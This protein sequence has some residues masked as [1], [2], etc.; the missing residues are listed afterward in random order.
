MDLDLNKIYMKTTFFLVSLAII[1]SIAVK[2][3]QPVIISEDSLKIGKSLMP[4]FSVT[5]PE[6]NYDKTMKAWIKELQ[7]GTKSDV[8]TEN[9]EMTIFGAKLKAISP[10]PVNVYSRINKL[11]SMLKLSVS[12]ETKKDVYIERSQ[13]SAEYIR[14]RDYIKEFAKNQYLEVAQEQKDTEERKLR[15]LQKELSSLMNEKTKL[16]KSIQSDTSSILEEKSNILTQNG[17][18]ATV[19][20]TLAEANSQIAGMEAG[21][22]QKEKADLI[23]ELE[24]RKKKALSSIDNSENRINKY[25][26]A[27]DKARRE[28]PVNE[29]MQVQARVQVVVQEK[30]YQK[31]SEKLAKI[32]AY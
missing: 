9:E 25:S 8:V 11:D 7:A 30:I 21:P 17:E 12:I 14:V 4:G 13:N 19:N 20:N 22:A 24:K 10:N 32:K 16:L 29:R 5:I 3:Q 15:D 31:Y 26:N 1:S 6:A 18:L 23:K 27:I 2:A 28:I